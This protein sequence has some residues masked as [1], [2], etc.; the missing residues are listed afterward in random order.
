MKLVFEDL[1]VHNKDIFDQIRNDESI[2]KFIHVDDNYYDY[3]LSSSHI[4]YKLIKHNHLYVG[5][6]HVEL[7]DYYATFSIEIM[8]Q[9]QG[10]GIGK[11]IV[12]L[13]KQNLF[14]FNIRTYKVYVETHNTSSI[15]LFTKSGFIKTDEKDNI[16]EYIYHI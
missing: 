2:R 16:I 12:D 9:N 11:C 3:L 8:T 15:E 13:L 1:S 5:G 14:D 4:H 6:L 7:I 10:K